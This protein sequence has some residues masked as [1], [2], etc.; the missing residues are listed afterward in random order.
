VRGTRCNRA[1]D[2]VNPPLRTFVARH[3]A[4]LARLVALEHPDPGALLCWHRQG[5][6]HVYLT[7]LPGAERAWLDRRALR[8]IHGPLYGWAGRERPAHPHRLR[9]RDRFGDLHEGPD[10]WS[11]PLASRPGCGPTGSDAHRHY[12]AFAGIC[13]GVTGVRYVVWA[14]RARAVAVIVRRGREHLPMRPGTAGWDWCSCRR[15]GPRDPCLARTGCP[16]GRRAPLR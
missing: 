5:P 14:P 6:A 4:G 16:V 3:T 7:F 8:R 10:P 13:G 9:W 1:P 11:L 12:G 2:A 15:R